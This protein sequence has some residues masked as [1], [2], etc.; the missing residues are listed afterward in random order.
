MRNPKM[1][2][3]KLLH[4]GYPSNYADQ[5]Y[6]SRLEGEAVV[7]ADI[8]G[9]KE[10]LSEDQTYVFKTPIFSFTGDEFNKHPYMVSRVAS[11]YGDSGGLAFNADKQCVIGPHRGGTIGKSA[12]E[13][14]SVFMNLGWQGV[15]ALLPNN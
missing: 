10:Q 13:N 8:T 14:Y 6:L 3:D 1:L 11:F 4:F 12:G 9:I 2:S 5:N 15:R 7:Y